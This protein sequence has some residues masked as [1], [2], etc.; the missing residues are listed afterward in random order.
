MSRPVLRD[1]ERAGLVRSQSLWVIRPTCP[2]ATM[3]PPGSTSREPLPA[4]GNRP[5]QIPAMVRGEARFPV[6][7]AGADRNVPGVGRRRDLGPQHGD[8][9]LE[10]QRE[11]LLVA[12]PIRAAP[13]AGVGLSRVPQSASRW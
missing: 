11:Q 7:L 5:R 4:L 3:A 1:A 2:L 6:A 10:E 12:R 13:A 8:V 9:H